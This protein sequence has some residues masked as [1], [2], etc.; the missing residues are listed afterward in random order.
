[1]NWGAWAKPL[2]A[3]TE[4]VIEKTE[5]GYGGRSAEC[6][7]TELVEQTEGSILSR[8]TCANALGLSQ[9]G[10]QLR[11]LSAGHGLIRR[12]TPDVSSVLKLIRRPTG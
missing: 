11:N 9:P 1:M 2:A 3:R 6:C 4:E 7:T 5:G 12:F 10:D 8:V